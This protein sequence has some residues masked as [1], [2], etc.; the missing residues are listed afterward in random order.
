V[1]CLIIFLGKL[2]LLSRCTTAAL[3]LMSAPIDFRSYIKV[4]KSLFDKKS[5][6]RYFM[7]VFGLI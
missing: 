2:Y 7:V 6:P 4:L 5:T 3:R 1:N